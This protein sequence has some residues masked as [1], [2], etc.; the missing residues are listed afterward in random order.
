[1]A[2]TFV[3]LEVARIFVELEVARTFVELE[4]A[5]IFVELDVAR[6]FVELDPNIKNVVT[7]NKNTFKSLFL[8]KLLT[9]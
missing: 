7:S 1:M 2:R 6:T 9:V 4:V 5:R 8:H 3:E